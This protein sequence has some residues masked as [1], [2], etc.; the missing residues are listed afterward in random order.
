M[1]VLAFRAEYERRLADKR[2]K[3]R[4]EKVGVSSQDTFLT[5]SGLAPAR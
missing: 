2:A 5:S 1:R 3:P 4:M